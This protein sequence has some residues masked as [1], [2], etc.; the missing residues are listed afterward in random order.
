MIPALNEWKLPADN[1]KVTDSSG[2]LCVRC[3]TIHVTYSC[4]HKEPRGGGGRKHACIPYCD[5][6]KELRHRTLLFYKRLKV[7]IFHSIVVDTIEN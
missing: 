2:C 6:K 4:K 5:S 7:N 3:A 1:M